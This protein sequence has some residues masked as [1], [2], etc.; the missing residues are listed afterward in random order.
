MSL[1]GTND[2]PIV[3]NACLVTPRLKRRRERVCQLA[4][5]NG[6]PRAVVRKVDV[7]DPLLEYGET[8]SP[9]PAPAPRAQA[10]QATGEAPPSRAPAREDDTFSAWL[11]Y[12][13]LYRLVEHAEVSPAPTMADVAREVCREKGIALR[14][15]KGASKERDLVAARWEA[16]FKMRLHTGRSMA[17]IGRFL[18]GRDHS[19]VSNGIQKYA[20]QIGAEIPKG[21]GERDG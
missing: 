13:L 6:K 17:A 4:A 16:M 21:W 2:D 1:I 18:G 7:R 10:V 19:T 9:A 15:L 11:F 8:P 3:A 20:A 5:E 14:D 12:F